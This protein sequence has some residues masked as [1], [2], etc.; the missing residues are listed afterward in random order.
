MMNK[1][2]KIFKL[3]YKGFLINLA[4]RIYINKK[5]VFSIHIK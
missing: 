1:N 2:A 3:I 4:K 5:S